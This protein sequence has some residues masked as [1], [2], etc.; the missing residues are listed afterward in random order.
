MLCFGWLLSAH[1][2]SF[3]F[4]MLINIAISCGVRSVAMRLIPQ[5]QHKSRAP[6]IWNTQHPNREK[7]FFCASPGMPFLCSCVAISR[8]SPQVS[9]CSALRFIC[10][11]NSTFLANRS[12]GFGLVICGRNVARSILPF[13][14][15]QG[16]QQ[17]T[18]FDFLDRPPF[19][20]GIMWSI[21]KFECDSLRP[22]YAQ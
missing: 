6:D 17:R 19:D 7:R 8:T 3:G 15:L 18:R 14:W 9:R 11:I 16:L 20:S 10:L 21:V 4:N 1:F 22:Q 2:I 5:S 13:F 12:G